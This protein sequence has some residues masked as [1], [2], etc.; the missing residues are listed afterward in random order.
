MLRLTLGKLLAERAQLIA[1]KELI[2]VVAKYCPGT[3]NSLVFRQEDATATTNSS[4]QQNANEFQHTIVAALLSLGQLVACLGSSVGNEL[5]D[6]GPAATA[7]PGFKAGGILEVV[8]SAL[9]HPSHAPKVAAAWVL[10]CLCVAAPSNLTLTLDEC[11]NG[12]EGLKDNVDAISGY[13]CA[14]AALLG[15]VR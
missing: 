12:L 8:F 3:K 9:Q 10:R 11:L 2:A 13:S 7:R 14:I 4:S 1:C 15:A 6:S 5:L